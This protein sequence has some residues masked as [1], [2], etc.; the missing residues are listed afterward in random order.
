M[1]ACA[2]RPAV[3]TQTRDPGIDLHVAL[4]GRQK[5]QIRPEEAGHD[6]GGMRIQILSSA[7]YQIILEISPGHQKFL[8]PEGSDCQNN[9][10]NP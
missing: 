2:P 5:L 1:I 3:L 4:H 8:I 7:C 10:C 6:G 9:R